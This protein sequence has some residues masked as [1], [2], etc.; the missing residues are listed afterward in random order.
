MRVMP[1]SLFGRLLGTAIVALLVAL[2]FSAVAIGHVLERFVMHGLD[3]RLDAQIALVARAVRPDGGLDRGRLVDVPPFDAPG[4]GWA[5]EIAAPGGTARS[6]SLVGADIVVPVAPPAPVPTHG[7]RR[8]RVRPFD[9]GAWGPGGTHGRVLLVTTAAGIARIVAAGPRSIAT[10]PLHAAMRPLL[11]SLVLLG[12]ALAGAILV[13]L[14]V[15]L[16]PLGL[17]RAMLGEVRAG[18]R[19]HV[20]AVEPTELLPLIAELNALIDANRVA[21]DQARGHVANLAHGLKTPLAALRL[22]LE[23]PGRDPDGRLGRHVERIDRHVRHHLGRAR[24]ASPAGAGRIATEI[25]PHAVDIVDA[26]ARIHA[27][28]PVRATIAI[29][30]GLAVRCDPQDVDEVLGNLL[31]NGWRWAAASLRVSAE[32]A[33]AIVRI[34]IADDG[35]GIAADAVARALQPGARLDERGDGHG[36]G[37]SIAREIVELYGGTLMLENAS[38][39]GLVATVTLPAA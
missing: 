21:L 8:D 33:D 35:P 2:A 17:V 19:V 5:W 28:R 3:E 16:K 38:T 24:A 25:A 34:A 26:L 36:F 37:L 15:G 31:D 7:P 1:R 18:T 13:Q 12:V 27:E 30:A 20:D 32:R 6:R 22:D 14:R 10:R 23:A 29:P 9:S 4:S 39:G 11:L